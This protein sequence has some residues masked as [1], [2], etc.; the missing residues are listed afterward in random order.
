MAALARSESALRRIEDIATY[1]PVD[2]S[3]LKPGDLLVVPTR[4]PLNDLDHG[5]KVHSQPG[6]TSIEQKIFRIFFAAL[7]VKKFIEASSR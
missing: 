2:E 1:K 7:P 6:F 4:P 3:F 5:D